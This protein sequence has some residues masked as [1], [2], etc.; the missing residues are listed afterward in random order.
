[1]KYRKLVCEAVDGGNEVDVPAIRWYLVLKHYC[2]SEKV[3][4][5]SQDSSVLK[6]HPGYSSFNGV[7]KRCGSDTAMAVKVL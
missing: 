2:T 7:A 1:M 3:G 4:H 5:Q 6:T